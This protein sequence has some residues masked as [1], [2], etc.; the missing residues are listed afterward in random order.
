M[1][2]GK[3]K[4]TMAFGAYGTLRHLRVAFLVFILMLITCVPSM[5][6]TA[7]CG[8]FVKEF[9]CFQPVEDKR[10]AVRCF[11]VYF[12]EKLK[13]LQEQRGVMPQTIEK[14]IQRVSEDQIFM[15][16]E[17]YYINRDGEGSPYFIKNGVIYIDF[18]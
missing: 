15:S 14:L 3:G 2:K 12:D 4:L 5:G 18:D 6:E 8:E 17:G 16:G 13:I 10:D 1:K 9:E 7:Y 11:N